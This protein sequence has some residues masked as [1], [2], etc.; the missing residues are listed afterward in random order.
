MTH[1]P[2][3]ETTVTLKPQDEASFLLNTD[4]VSDIPALSVIPEGSDFSSF[5]SGL[6]RPSRQLSSTYTPFS[7]NNASDRVSSGW[8]MTG[9]GGGGR[10]PA[11]HERAMSGPDVM[12]EAFD[13][14]GAV[15]V[16]P[17]SEMN[18][19]CGFI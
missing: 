3:P 10:G 16:R 17:D 19:R 11:S 9:R 12:Q 14:G 1:A 2:D 5:E 15:V 4:V 6:A 7:S 18:S 8:P 13:M